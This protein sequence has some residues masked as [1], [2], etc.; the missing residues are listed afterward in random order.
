MRGLVRQARHWG[1]FPQRL[2]DAF[3]GDAVA[4]P[5]LPGCGA[6]N[7]MQSPWNIPAYAEALHADIQS[8]PHPRVMVAMSLGGMVA[9]AL[10]LQ[11]PSDLDGLVL[12]NSSLA[13]LSP[14]HRRLQ[15]GAW[16]AVF[17]T[18][19]CRTPQTR[20]A[21]ILGLVSNRP[22]K[23]AQA[24]PHWGAIAREAPV[25][26]ANSARQLAAAARFRLPTDMPGLA[27]PVTVLSSLGDRL[28]HPSCSAA[29]G[30]AL[31]AR[32]A[33]HPDAG[34]DLPLD[35]PEWVAGQLREFRRNLP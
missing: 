2:R 23:R 8:L 34:H 3:P 32:A 22:E 6:K 26:L 5:D 12:L 1:D 33:E 30:R 11:Y 20:E 28:A 19:A 18:L 35:A 13:G 4:C 27:M 21:R 9:T 15:P 25:S 10:A 14:F 29:M 16:P 17:G 31:K 7:R 24:L